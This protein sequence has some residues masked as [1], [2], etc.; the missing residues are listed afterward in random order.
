MG[1]KAPDIEQEIETLRAESDRILDEL[2]RRIRDAVNVR[3]QAEH[4]P[5]VTTAFALGIM[6]GV[7]MLVY[8]LL[9]RARLP[10]RWRT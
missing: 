2:E 3:T 8:S 1:K 9:I 4:H 10:N 6:A 7:G 5:I